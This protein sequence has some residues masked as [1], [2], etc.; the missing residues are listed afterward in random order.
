MSDLTDAQ[1]A[2]T[3]KI[4]GSDTSGVESN[5]VGAQDTTTDAN[6]TSDVGLLAKIKSYIFN[7][8]TWDRKRSASV[9]NN[10]AATGL[11]ASVDYN[12][13]RTTIPSLTEGNYSASMCDERGIKVSTTSQEAFASQE[14]TFSATTNLIT[15]GTAET[16]FL[17]FR[18]PT[19]SGKFVRVYSIRISS[20]DAA[21]FRV[22]QTPTV[23][24][25]GTAVTTL[26]NYVKSG[27]A[28]ASST[29]F[30]QPTTSSNGTLYHVHITTAEEGTIELQLEQHIILDANNAILITVANGSNNT[31]TNASISW[32]EI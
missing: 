30:S 15:I 29:V 20:D 32:I 6:V 28:A 12:Q 22:Y 17:L 31:P 26:N 27:A 9:G 2:Q 3:T 25:N 24:A 14:K 13:Y 5:F 16:P 19:G 10:I 18:N 23:T 1:A 4:V 8:T 7:G 11:D 21:T